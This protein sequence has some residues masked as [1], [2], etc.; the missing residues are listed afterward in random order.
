[1]LGQIKSLLV[2]K[3]RIDG[4]EVD[5]DVFFDCSDLYDLC[6]KVETIMGIEP[7]AALWYVT[8]LI[9]KDMS[10]ATKMVHAI[11]ELREACEE[12]SKLDTVTARAVRNTCYQRQGSFAKYV[13]KESE[14]IEDFED[15]E[16]RVV[17]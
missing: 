15:L 9:Q 11:K 17:K 4:V 14:I 6:S 2:L 7:H 5:D 3:L 8:P 10:C 13:L 1:M 12:Y 16:R